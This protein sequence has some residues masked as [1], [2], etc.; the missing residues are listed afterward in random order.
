M[1]TCGIDTT[2]FIRRIFAILV[3]VTSVFKQDTCTRV[4][5]EFVRFTPTVHFIRSIP[6]IIDFIT[7]KALLYTSAISAREVSF[8]AY[9]TLTEILF[10][11]TTIDTMCVSITNKLIW[12]ATSGLTQEHALIASRDTHIIYSLKARKANA[13]IIFNAD[14]I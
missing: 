2:H 9:T 5:T 6:T 1:V 7:L 14:F 3:I 11:I 4:T 10:L 8:R 12:N 13:I